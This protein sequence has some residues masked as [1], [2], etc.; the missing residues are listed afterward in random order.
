MNAI[1]NLILFIFISLLLIVI[2]Q[3][4]AD[5]VQIQSKDISV[6]GFITSTIEKDTNVYIGGKFS[7]VTMDDKTTGR[8]NL[9]EINLTN[10]Y[11]TSWAPEPNGPVHDM[12]NYNDELVIAGQFTTINGKEKS[13]I[14]AIN[15]NNKEL[16]DLFINP[17]APVYALIRNED[18]LYIG[19][20]FTEINGQIRNHFAA[21]NLATNSLADW[22]P[23]FNDTIYDLF[24][25]GN[26]LYVGGAFTEINQTAHN[27]I[28]AFDISSQS[29]LDWN[30]NID[31][32]I[33]HIESNGD[34]IIVTGFKKLDE[35]VIAKQITLDPENATII[36]EEEITVNEAT[37]TIFQNDP[38]E[39]TTEG[40]MISTDDLGFK[41]PSLGDILTFTI[42][43][44]FVIGG[45]AA[46]FFMLLGAFAWVTSGGDSEAVTAAQQKIQAAVVG[47]LIMVAVLALV[48]TL[49]QVIF[50][51]RICLG[52]SC[53]ITIPSLLKPS[54]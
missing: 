25:K 50:N 34:S 4:F 41:I 33:T 10:N 29:I 12:A 39:S 20:S 17:N 44:F 2:P 48:W 31:M 38:E 40:L 11:V 47:L 8:P 37:Q 13:Y 30:P 24:Q 53:P 22:D 51:R 18:M 45:L 42:R 15:A 49:E 32:T 16:Q 6:N 52:L 14:A 35:E 1:K 26:I 46:L 36:K 3:V 23:N 54:E 9:V 7:S 43:S 27:H 21:F 28:A 5:T 19:G